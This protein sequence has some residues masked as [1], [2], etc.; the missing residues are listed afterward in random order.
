MGAASAALLARP[1]AWAE[2]GSVEAQLQDLAMTAL[3]KLPG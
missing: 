2:R 1:V 3:A